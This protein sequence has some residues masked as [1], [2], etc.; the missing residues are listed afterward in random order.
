MQGWVEG[1]RNGWRDAGGERDTWKDEERYRTSG[2]AEMETQ[3]EV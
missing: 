3:R 2:Q 1:C